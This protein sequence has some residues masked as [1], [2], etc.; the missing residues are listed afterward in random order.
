MWNVQGKTAVVT[1]ATSGVGEET[2]F[3]LLRAG[4]HVVIVGRNEEKM[5]VTVD[6]LRVRSGSGS[7]DYVLADLSVM[8]EV[9]AAA[10]E[11]HR[12]F[13]R[14]DILVNNAGGIFLDRETTDEG[15][16]KTFA[17]NHLG[18]FLLTTLLLPTLERS[19]PSRIITVSS[20]GHVI[21]KMHFDDLQL[22]KGWGSFKAYAQAKLG[23]ILFTRSLAKRLEGTGVTAN[24]LHPG[25]VASNFAK[26]SGVLGA[27]GHAFTKTFGMSPE[28]GAR[29]S[30]HL[31]MSDEVATVSGEYF[32]GLKVR[33]PS[34]AA[35]DD[36]QAKKLWEVSELLVRAAADLHR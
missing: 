8:R 10:N 25:F 26:K 15:F 28:K 2:A 34:A 27:I 17:L 32:I 24:V 4:A 35:R 11:L 19:A 30:L 9:R 21:G 12:R 33:K 14:I 36:E 20:G 7:T 16:E 22:T 18:V 5:K 3:G 23:S 29:T 1:G 13:P 6:R 31:A